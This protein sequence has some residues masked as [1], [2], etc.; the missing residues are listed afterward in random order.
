MQ[1]IDD[2][3]SNLMYHARMFALATLGGVALF[4]MGI[5]VIVIGLW[6]GIWH[7]EFR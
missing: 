7:G 6:L 4:L 3:R 2:K 5:G 1:R